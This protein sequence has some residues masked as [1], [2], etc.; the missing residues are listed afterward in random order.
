VVFGFHLAFGGHRFGLSETLLP[1]LM[2]LQTV[3]ASL[4][5]LQ[6]RMF[7]YVRGRVSFSICLCPVSSEALASKDCGQYIGGFGTGRGEADSLR[8]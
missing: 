5:R 2:E 6:M 1:G 4:H 3:F 8:E 7:A